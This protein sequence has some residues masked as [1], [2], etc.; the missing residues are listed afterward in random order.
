MTV[1]ARAKRP[2]ATET[3]CEE[4]SAERPWATRVQSRRADARGRQPLRRKHPAG[5]L[6]LPLALVGAH[7]LVAH[8]RSARRPD[9]VVFFYA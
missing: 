6:Q 7:L 4:R 3:T 9:Q 8:G 5:R 2:T 1:Q